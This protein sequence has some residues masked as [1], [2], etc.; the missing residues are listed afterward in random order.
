MN[1]RKKVELLAPAGNMEK[2]LTAFHFGADAV[3]IAGKSF[4]LRAFAD[5]F[6]EKEMVEAI[7]IAHALGKKVYVTVNIYARNADFDGLKKYLVFLQNAGA[8]AA[9]MSDAGVIAVSKEVAPGLPIHISTQANTLN[10]YAVK[11]WREQ[12]AERVV[13]A[14]ECRFEDIAEINSFVPTCETEVFVHGAMCISYSGRCLMS[15][16]LTGRGANRGECVQACRWEWQ[17][18]EKEHEDKPL[19]VRE[20]AR[21]TYVFNSKDLNLI[22]RIKEL[23]ECGVASFKIEGRMKSPYYVA[24]VVNAYRRAID[25]YYARPDDYETDE[26]IAADLFKTTHRQFTEGFTFYDGEVM[27]NYETSR[28]TGD[29]E[30]LAVVKDYSDGVATVEMRSRFKE[31]QRVEILSPSDAFGRKVEIKNLRDVNDLPVEDAKR[32]QQILKFDCPYRL[33]PNDILR[34]E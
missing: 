29:S 15:D 2:L 4:G 7:D 32:V 24:T 1:E 26:R 22:H 10:K 20:D 5:N 19:T 13:L 9:I 11:F 6:D 8:D 18:T 25:A 16:F 28:A 33:L 30:F 31:G 21:G 17:I 23:I 14:R 27:Q 3:Y 12:G 34:T